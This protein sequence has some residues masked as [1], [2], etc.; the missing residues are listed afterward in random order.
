MNKHDFKFFWPNPPRTTT[1][2]EWKAASRWL[3]ECRKIVE[4]ELDNMNIHKKIMD[5]MLYGK[6]IN[7]S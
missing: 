4:K 7:L 1:K 2:S 5:A 3:R 6:P